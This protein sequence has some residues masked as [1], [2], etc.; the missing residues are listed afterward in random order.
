MFLIIIINQAFIQ[1]ALSQK[2]NDSETINLSGRQRMLS[3]KILNLSYEYDQNK[4]NEVFDD[5]QSKYEQWKSNH[6]RIIENL[7]RV[8]LKKQEVQ[9]LIKSL[10]ELDPYFENFKSESYKLFNH[11]STA[12]LRIKSNQNNFLA[13]MDQLVNRLE[14]LSDAKL[15]YVIRLEI[16]LALISLFILFMEF[17]YIYNRVISKLEEQNLALQESNKTL[18][19][20]TYMAAHHLSSSSRDI[21]NMSALIKRNSESKL[22]PKD[23]VYLTLIN[24]AAK[25]YHDTTKSM[26]QISKLNH[27]EIIKE[28]FDFIRLCKE[29][30]KDLNF[31]KD[32]TVKYKI[33][34]KVINADLDLARI[35]VKHLFENSYKFRSTDLLTIEV[36]YN[37]QQEC[38][39][40]IDNGIGIEPDQLEEMFETFKKL[41]SNNEI[42]GNGIGLSICKSIIEKH[43]GQ[44]KAI[45]NI[46]SGIRICFSLN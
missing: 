39:E 16:F 4:S 23:S 5:I 33:R 42:S 8:K 31:P 15:S 6:F 22:N 46:G 37:M 35:L 24:N 29:V 32:V 34:N 14:I 38:F 43:E 9:Y 7:K 2:Q 11:D 40:I 3:Q 36:D 25:R 19:N 45:N 26:I 20:F 27:Y 10:N 13:E 18:S 30:E 44:I 1:F 21:I 28:E 12:I 17:R 41:H